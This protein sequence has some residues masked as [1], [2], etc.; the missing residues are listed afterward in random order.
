MHAMLKEVTFKFAIA[1]TDTDFAE[2]VADFINGKQDTFCGVCA[3]EF[4][5]DYAGAENVISARIGLDDISVQ[6]FEALTTN[7]DSHV[8]I[9]VTPRKDLLSI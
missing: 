3:H 8:K 2:T 1:Y 6:G 7:K 4:S 9:L 5:G